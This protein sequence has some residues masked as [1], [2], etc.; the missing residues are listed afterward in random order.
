MLDLKRLPEGLTNEKELTWLF[1][2][3]QEKRPSNVVELG[4]WLGR[5]LCAMLQAV[6]ESDT[7]F[8]AIDSWEEE[9]AIRMGLQ[10]NPAVLFEQYIATHYRHFLND[11]DI[12]KGSTFENARKFKDK[13]F[14][15]MFHDA[16]HDEKSVYT[17]LIEW[18]PKMRDD[19]FICGHDLRPGN[20]VDLATKKFCSAKGFKRFKIQGGTLWQLVR[21]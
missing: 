13:Y 16:A 15:F 5:S 4:T 12:I 18:L 19:A 7:K 20:G 21:K 17:D 1:N 10:E 14:D 6:D 3:V 2:R 8:V 11:I 9:Y